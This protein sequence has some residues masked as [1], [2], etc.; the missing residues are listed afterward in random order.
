VPPARPGNAPERPWPAAI[1]VRV[2]IWYHPAFDGI[3]S[4]APARLGADPLF[5][6]LFL[7]FDT[8][9]SPRSAAIGDLNDGGKSGPMVANWN[10]NRVSVLAVWCKP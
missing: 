10:S 1:P 3:T 2:A 5:A 9:C 4:A 7:S 8:G 6:V